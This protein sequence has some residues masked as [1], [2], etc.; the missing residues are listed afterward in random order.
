MGINPIVFQ[1]IAW[2]QALEFQWIDL[3]GGTVVAVAVLLWEKFIADK[4][5]SSK[6]WLAGL[7]VAFVLANFMAWKQQADRASQDEV[8]LTAL[9]IR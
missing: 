3:V 9:T 8:N 6:G 7:V 2:F 1:F 5:I 4:P